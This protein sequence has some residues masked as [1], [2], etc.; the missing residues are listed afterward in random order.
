M[1]NVDVLHFCIKCNINR[2]IFKKVILTIDIK[3][4]DQPII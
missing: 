3:T 1:Y 2:D 4:I